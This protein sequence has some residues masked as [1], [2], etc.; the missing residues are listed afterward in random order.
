MHSSIHFL[1][2]MHLHLLIHFIFMITE[3]LTLLPMLFSPLPKKISVSY[4]SIHKYFRVNR[5]K[6]YSMLVHLVISENTDLNP[7]DKIR[8]IR[9]LLSNYLVFLIFVMKE[10]FR[11]ML[12]FTWQNYTNQQPQVLE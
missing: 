10:T 4:Y 8:L 1:K 12:K 7:V 6:T 11:F 9:M 3:S 5:F 2:S